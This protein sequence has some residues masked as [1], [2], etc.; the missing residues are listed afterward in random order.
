MPGFEVFGEEEKKEIAEVLE[1]G[2]LFRYGFEDQRRGHFK[3]AEF[4]RRFADMCGARYSLAVSSG[5]AALRVAMAALGISPGDEVITQG[6][7]FIATW[8][9]ILESGG[10]PVFAEVDDTL[11]MDPADL[12]DKITDRTKAIIPVHMIG[13]QANIQEVKA[14][15]DG[16]GIPVIED[17]AQAAG[18]TLDGDYLGTFGALGTF[19]FDSVKTM[20]TGEGGMI[21]TDDENLYFNCFTFHDHGHEHVPDVDRGLD[22][23]SFMGFNYRMMELQGALGLAQ[24]SKLPSIIQEQKKNKELIKKA[25]GKIDGITFRRILD[26]DGDT[27][28]F[29]AFFLPD[30]EKTRRFNQVLSNNNAGAIYYKDNTWHYYSNWNELFEGTTLCRNGWPFENTPQGI[31]V[32]YQKNA[33]PRTDALFERLLVYPIS[34]KMPEERLDTITSAIEAAAKEVL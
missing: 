17:T 18:G 31:G 19:S 28:T 23:R 4:E 10:V 3:V 11:C 5:S 21:L 6:F 9:A 2:V 26:A 33:L 29:L 20:T 1:T 25:L 30:E 24:L 27:A 13:A 16:H 15:A 7:T 12:A 8:E 22:K 34:V 32:R 14:I